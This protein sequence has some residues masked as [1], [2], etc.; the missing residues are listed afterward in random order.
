LSPA[1]ENIP[2]IV[3]ANIQ[4]DQPHTLARAAG[5]RNDPLGGVRLRTGCADKRRAGLARNA[6]I[7][8]F[9]RRVQHPRLVE[10]QRRITGLAVVVG[11]GLDP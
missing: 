5:A 6:G 4:R 10:Q 3:A 7:L 11:G 9:Q 1:G 2:K 8:E